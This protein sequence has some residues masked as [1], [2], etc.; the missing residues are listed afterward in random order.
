ML[1]VAL[2]DAQQEKLLTRHRWSSRNSGFRPAT[3]VTHGY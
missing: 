1:R 3:I 2:D